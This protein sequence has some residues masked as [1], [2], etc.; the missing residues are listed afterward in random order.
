MSAPKH[1]RDITAKGRYYGSCGED[2]PFGDRLFISVTNA[3]SVINKPALPPSAAKI[4]AAA[5]WNLL[6][7]M[8]RTSRQPEVGRP[9]D[10][11]A[12]T[13]DKRSPVS[14]RCGRCRFCITAAIKAA[15]RQEWEAKAE[16]GTRIHTAAH[17]HVLGEPRPYDEE[18]APFLDQYL[19]FLD[20]W[21]VDLDKD[22]EAAETTIVDWDKEYAG[23]GDIWLWL[24]LPSGASG[25][26]AR[27]LVL[28]DIK[29]SVDKPASV[30]Y[31]DQEIQLAGLR[32]APKALMPDDSEVDVPKFD[33]AAILNLRP[34]AH[35]LIPVPTGRGSYK[36]F[37]GA[38]DLQRHFHSQ[39][40]KAWNPVEH[41]PVPAPTR[42]AS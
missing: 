19:I 25:R 42:K 37:L 23:T 2:C 33:A 27:K 15:Y 12:K 38:V 9:V 10:G 32:Y 4:T 3:Q 20:R 39:D 29:T 26:R 30:I 18:I 22:V 16:L 21:G 13:C 5:A 31:P 34:N 17:A 40:T 28:V 11:D 36:A 14:K 6:P 35:A 24:R 7:Q 1:A 8:V 41:P